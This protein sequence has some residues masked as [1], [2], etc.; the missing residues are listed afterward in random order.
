M[1]Q[2]GKLNAVTIATNMAGRGTDI[3]LGGNPDMMARLDL[4]QDRI[5]EERIEEAVGYG[6]P[7]PRM[8]T[9]WHSASV[10]RSCMKNIKRNA[11]KNT[12]K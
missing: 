5:E 4:R 2:A 8:K 11:T 9:Y 10:T 7:K 6:E 1:A 12:K 3:I